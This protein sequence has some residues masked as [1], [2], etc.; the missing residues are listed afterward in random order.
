MMVLLKL[1]VVY[2]NELEYVLFSNL[3]ILKRLIHSHSIRSCIS[4]V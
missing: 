3:A 1:V 2:C 4:E